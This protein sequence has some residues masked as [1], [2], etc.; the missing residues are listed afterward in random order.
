MAKKGLVVGAFVALGEVADTSAPGCAAAR[1][2]E[3]EE[4]SM[5]ETKAVGGWY[6]VF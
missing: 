5:V 1:A 6:C 4:R 2:L 3:A